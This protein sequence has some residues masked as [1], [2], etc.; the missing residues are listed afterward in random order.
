M[1]QPKPDRH[2][3]EGDGRLRR[4]RARRG[5][6]AGAIKA[7]GR[8]ALVHYMGRLVRTGENLRRHVGC[9]CAGRFARPGR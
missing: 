3:T 6:R 2:L 4:V 5:G 9:Y 8:R 1:I 7:A